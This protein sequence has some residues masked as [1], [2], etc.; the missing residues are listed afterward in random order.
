[1]V[2]GY[3]SD[4]FKPLRAIGAF[5]MLNLIY[6]APLA[7]TM[8]SLIHSAIVLGTIGTPE[9]KYDSC[10]EA[11]SL[12]IG[13]NM[14][15]WNLLDGAIM[16]A[17]ILV[18][19]VA[20]MGLIRKVY[21]E[22]NPGQGGQWRYA[23]YNLTTLASKDTAP[24]INILF[25]LLMINSS[26]SLFITGLHFRLNMADETSVPKDA[27]CSYNDNGVVKVAPIM[28]IVLSKIILFGV[29]WLVIAVSLVIYSFRIASDHKKGY[30]K[31]T[32]NE[33]TAEMAVSANGSAKMSTAAYFSSRK[34]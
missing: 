33:T 12:V 4:D 3:F 24:Y 28:K 31:L 17:L 13:L 16:S 11:D 27:G 21:A 7:I 19:F 9:F 1:M 25:M 32:R 5:I 20:F 14:F 15:Q 23:L 2:L 10:V 29:S 6:I 22:V 34:K 8:T 26:I 30:I 18:L